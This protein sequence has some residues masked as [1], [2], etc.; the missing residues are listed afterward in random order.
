MAKMADLTAEMYRRAEAEVERAVG[1]FE[2]GENVRYTS[3]SYIDGITPGWEP[4]AD[5][6]VLYPAGKPVVGRLS[7]HD[8]EEPPYGRIRYYTNVRLPRR[9]VKLD[10]ARLRAVA[11]HEAE[12]TIAALRK[13]EDAADTT[14]ALRC[15]YFA[16]WIEGLRDEFS[17]Q[18]SECA[19][20]CPEKLETFVSHAHLCPKGW[21]GRK[22]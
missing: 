5:M 16:V 17:R 8:V 22:S 11:R 1:E 20:T 4:N 12:R 19:R 14:C 2:R 3:F 15:L 21:F 7:S 10:V 6:P 9:L 13:K 18:F